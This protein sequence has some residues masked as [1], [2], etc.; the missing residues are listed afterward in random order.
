MIEIVR[1]N[2]F[3]RLKSIDNSKREGPPLPFFSTTKAAL[4]ALVFL[5]GIPM[6]MGATQ[7]FGGE[8]VGGSSQVAAIRIQLAGDLSFVH[9]VDCKGAPSDICSNDILVRINA[10][11]GT[12]VSSV[13][14]E[15]AAQLM[16]AIESA[17]ALLPESVELTQSLSIDNGGVRL[18]PQSTPF[19]IGSGAWLLS[20]SLVFLYW[21]QKIRFVRSLII[22]TALLLPVFWVTIGGRWTGRRMLGHYI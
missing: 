3:V 16:A 13:S 15:D 12:E 7:T 20:S 10:S 8:A 2:F 6:M 22:S 14:P 4:A 19:A 9:S 18:V 21:Q 11:G 1:Y 17:R 5:V